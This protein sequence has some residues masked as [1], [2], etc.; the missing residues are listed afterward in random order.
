[1]RKLLAETADPRGHE[2][3]INDRS[4]VVRAAVAATA[5]SRST[6]D[7]LIADPKPVVRAGAAA[8]P[9]LDDATQSVLAQ[10]RSLIVRRAVVRTGRAT[11]AVQ[12]QLANDRSID[13]RWWLA[14]MPATS[15]GVLEVLSNDADDDVANQAREAIRRANKVQTSYWFNCLTPSRRASAHRALARRDPG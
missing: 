7:R 14:T 12:R 3:F 1:M 10:D 9:M 8:N 15:V 13:V 4:P 11:H 5:Q 6:L 2:A